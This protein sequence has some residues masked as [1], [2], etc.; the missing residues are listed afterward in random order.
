MAKHNGSHSHARHADPMT[1]LVLLAVLATL[2]GGMWML[3][4]SLHTETESLRSSIEALSRQVSFEHD[5]VQ[6][7]M[8]DLAQKDKA[9]PL[10]SIVAPAQESVTEQDTPS[11]SKKE[12][13]KHR[14]RD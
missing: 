4:K 6:K 11:E 7:L 1:F 3:G 14:S 12:K 2:L 10:Q 5:K 8:S 9:L 13:K